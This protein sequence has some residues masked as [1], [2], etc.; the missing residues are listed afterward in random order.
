M[1]KITSIFNLV[2]SKIEIFTNF[3]FRIEFIYIYYLNLKFM[4]M[5]YNI[6]VVTYAKQT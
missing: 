6:W 1:F 2:F 4:I 5:A 3:M